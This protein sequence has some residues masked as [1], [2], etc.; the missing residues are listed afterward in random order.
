MSYFLQKN[1]AWRLGIVC[2]TVTLPNV[3]LRWH[4]HAPIMAKSSCILKKVLTKLVFF[5]YLG[6]SALQEELYSSRHKEDKEHSFSKDSDPS[7]HPPIVSEEDVSVS[8]SSFHE[9]TPKTEADLSISELLRQAQ[10]EHL[11]TEFSGKPQDLPEETSA[12]QQEYL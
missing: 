4:R 8:Y 10:K 2:F 5:L 1:S 9:G 3:V 7:D 6:F 12:T 11:Q